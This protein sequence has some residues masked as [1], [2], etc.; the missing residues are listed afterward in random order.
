ML[1]TVERSSWPA[2]AGL[3]AV[4]S[5][6]GLVLIFSLEL[7][8][9]EGYLGLLGPLY[10]C[11]VSLYFDTLPFHVGVHAERPTFNE[12]AWAA[13]GVERCI[14][15]PRLRPFPPPYFWHFL[16]YVGTPTGGG[17]NK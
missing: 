4:Q 10:N 16:Y 3:C 11:C 14:A 13:S 12:S 6:I 5:R 17:K 15:I 1:D 8:A 9:G 7:G 2:K